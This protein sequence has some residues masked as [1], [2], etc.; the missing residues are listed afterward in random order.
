MISLFNVSPELTWHK[1]E[2]IDKSLHCV[3]RPDPGPPKHVSLKNIDWNSFH[4]Y[5]VLDYN[6]IIDL[7]QSSI[8]YNPDNRQIFERISS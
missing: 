5:S 8:T 6:F 3:L 2:Y 1:P 4:K 7:K